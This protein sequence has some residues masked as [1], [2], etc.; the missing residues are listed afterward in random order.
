[1]LLEKKN[2]PFF[3][4]SLILVTVKWFLIALTRLVE[5]GEIENEDGVYYRPD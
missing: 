2:P 4:A 3:H 1:M 5:K